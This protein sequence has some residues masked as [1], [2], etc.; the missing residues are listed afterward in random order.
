MEVLYYEGREMEGDVKWVEGGGEVY[1]EWR[2]RWSIKV[3]GRW[4]GELCG[5]HI[6]E[7][8]VVVV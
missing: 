6:V 8:S 5:E 3:S 1:T 4:I 7:W 2:W